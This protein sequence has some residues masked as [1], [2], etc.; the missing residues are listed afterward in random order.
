MEILT[1]FEIIFKQFLRW[2]F[3]LCRKQGIEVRIVKRGEYDKNYDKSFLNNNLLLAKLKNFQFILLSLKQLN[4]VKAGE[5]AS[6]VSPSSCGVNS[7][8]I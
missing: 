7:S 2:S 1:V 8:S 4:F 6:L 3:R 5:T